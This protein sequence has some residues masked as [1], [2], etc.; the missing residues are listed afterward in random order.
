M[1]FRLYLTDGTSIVSYGEFAR[2]GDRVVFSMVMGGAEQPRLHATTLP[3]SAIDWTRTDLACRIH[4]V[5]VVRADP[6]RTKISRA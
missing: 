1:L 5:S 4:P 3:A 6:R 2:V